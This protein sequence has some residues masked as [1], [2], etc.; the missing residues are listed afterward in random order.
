MR[1]QAQVGERLDAAEK[2]GLVTNVE[3][4]RFGVA[5]E[6]QIFRALDRLVAQSV[7]EVRSAKRLHIVVDTEAAARVRV[8]LL[9]VAKGVHFDHKGCAVAVV[10]FQRRGASTEVFRPFTHDDFK[11]VQHSVHVPAGRQHNLEIVRQPGGECVIA[12]GGGDS[13]GEVVEI[14]PAEISCAWTI[15]DPAVVIFPD[16]RV[17]VVADA[18]F[19]LVGKAGA[20]ANTKGVLEDAASVV[21]VGFSIV[22]ARCGCVAARDSGNARPIVVEDRGGIVSHV[23]DGFRIGARATLAVARAKLERHAD[24]VVGISVF[25]NLHG[26][27][28]GERSCGGDLGHGNLEVGMVG[29]N[30]AVR[31]GATHVWQVVPCKAKDVTRRVDA[32]PCRRGPEEFVCPI[33]VS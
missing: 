10:E 15:A 8:D 5:G 2:I 28:A 23:V 26:Q 6:W 19:V 21:G 12:T 27:L 30:P 24:F 18:V 31:P 9:R 1:G 33:H 17:D 3:R 7:Q 16:A 29:G 25:E 4:F 22:V 14:R 32:G 20:S 13:N 11:S